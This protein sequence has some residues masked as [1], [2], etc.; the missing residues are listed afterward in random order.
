MT[1][2]E[3]LA[4]VQDVFRDIL[5]DSEL[6]ISGE[7]TADDVD[8]WDSLSHIQIVVAIEKAFKVKFSSNEMLSW[9]NIGEMVDAVI[10]KLG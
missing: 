9:K 6:N 5:D 7:T 2:E 3:V 8:D 1:K 10:T 4:K